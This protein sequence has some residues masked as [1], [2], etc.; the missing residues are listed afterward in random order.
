MEAVER[1]PWAAP[2]DNDF[3]PTATAWRAAKA[4]GRTERQRSELAELS[5]SIDKLSDSIDTVR[6]LLARLLALLKWAG[7]IVGG[8]VLTAGTAAALHWIATLHH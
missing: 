6:R 1:W 4:L 2:A 8:I 7:A 3:G 5:D